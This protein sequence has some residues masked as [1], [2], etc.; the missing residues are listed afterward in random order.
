MTSGTRGRPAGVRPLLVGAGAV[1]IALILLGAGVFALGALQGGSDGD[2]QQA[3]AEDHGT[4]HSPAG[5][6]GEDFPPFV[7]KSP[8]V[9]AGYRTAVQK[10]D[11][12]ARLPCYCGC[13]A[14]PEEPHRSLADCFLNEDGSYDPHASG[15]AIC[16]DITR[17]A[18]IWSA[19]GRSL[20][21]V[22]SLVEEKYGDAG[23][24]TDNPF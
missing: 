11:L 12:L 22:R 10:R 16:L 9:L 6:P 2:E 15:C 4:G 24:S 7:Y 13:V 5:A 8:E 1:L 18:A 3:V 23:P 19:E 17:D 14:L 21:E 20:A